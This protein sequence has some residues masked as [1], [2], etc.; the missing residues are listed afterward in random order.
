MLSIE[1]KQLNKVAGLASKETG[2]MGR[3]ASLASMK[4]NATRAASPPSSGAME[5]LGAIAEVSSNKSVVD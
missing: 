4:M 2:M 5:K 1:L 3:R